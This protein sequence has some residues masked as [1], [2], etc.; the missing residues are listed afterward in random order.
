MSSSTPSKKRYTSDITDAQWELIKPHLPLPRSGNG[1]PGRP[2]TTDLRE[3]WN[4]VAYLV[5]TQCQWENLPKDFPPKSTVFEHFT[6]WQCS[7]ALERINELLSREA[8]KRAN[9]EE[10]PSRAIMDAQSVKCTTAC[11]GGENEGL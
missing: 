9:R 10:T 6:R 4:A 7:G 11:Y 3:V 2:R 8:R 5:K 1:R